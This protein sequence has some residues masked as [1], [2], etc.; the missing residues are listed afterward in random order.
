MDTEGREP[1]PSVH[2]VLTRPTGRSTDP[3]SPFQLG[4]I[5]K[6]VLG[7]EDPEGQGWPQ[8]AEPGARCLRGTAPSGPGLLCP[9]LRP[10]RPQPVKILR[11]PHATVPV[12]PFLPLSGT[13][14]IPRSLSMLCSESNTGLTQ[15]SGSQAPASCT[16]PAG[17]CACPQS[18]LSSSPWTHSWWTGGQITLRLQ[19]ADGVRGCVA[20]PQNS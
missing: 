15:D 11:S 6:A 17:T 14:R 4:C 19:A 7:R 20:F 5:W 12:F 1:R 16:S 8:Q 9:P 13:R 3:L 2:R 10:P 18:H